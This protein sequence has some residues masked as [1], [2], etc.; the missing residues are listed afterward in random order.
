MSTFTVNEICYRLMHDGPFR[1]AMKGSMEDAL[2]NE[3]LTE[4]ERSA[5]LSRDIGEL[6][7]LGAHD[8][9]LANL[10]RAGIIKAPE[11]SERMRAMVGISIEDLAE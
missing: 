5:L 1:D 3:D 9:L 11:F 8:F 10:V 6:H 4:G 7:R 2:A